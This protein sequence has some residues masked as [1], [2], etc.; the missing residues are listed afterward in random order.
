M[1]VAGSGTR[2]VRR[3]RRV[4]G[5][6]P[7]EDWRD[8]ARGLPDEVL[9]KVAAKVVAQTVAGWAAYLK[10]Y[11]LTEGNIQR[12]ME[13]RK[14]YGNCL[15]VFAR[16]CREWRKAQ[17]KVGG[18]LRTRVRPDVIMPGSVA[19]AKWALAEG[20]PRVDRWGG[21]MAHHAALYGNL[22]LVKWLCG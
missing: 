19:L 5:L 9:A 1:A 7:E 16:V 22:E 18:P 6:P 12:K 10:V 20:C 11:G 17:L 3:S 8:W 2:G 21:T 13:Q 14:H 15:F 4:R